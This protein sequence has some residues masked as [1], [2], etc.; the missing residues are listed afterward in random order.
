VARKT[1]RRRE[2]IVALASENGLASVEAL[3]TQF[4]VTASTIRRDLAHLSSEGH[5][6]RTYGGA[7]AP[8]THVES[9]LREREQE[10]FAAKS[11]IAAWA[12]AQIGAGETIMLD[13]GSTTGLLARRLPALGAVTVVTA[14]IPAIAALQGRQD[15]ELICLGGRLRPLSLAFVGP[16]TELALERLTFDRLFLGTDGVSDDGAICEA[17]LDQTRMKEML[18]A[19]AREVYVLA[20]SAKL[21]QSPFN[22]WARLSGAWT[23]VTDTG[24]DPAFTERFARDGRSVVTVDAATA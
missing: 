21:G 12:A 11:A 8:R 16:L 5:L 20:H 7:I 2:E 14:S 23:L 9:S 15:V 13:A 24:A 18:A 3:A 6:A 22:S 19:R 17:E 10:G 4:G 1:E